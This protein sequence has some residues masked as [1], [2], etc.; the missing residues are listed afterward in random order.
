MMRVKRE[1]VGRKLSLLRSSLHFKF[2]LWHDQSTVY[3][4]YIGIG[5]IGFDDGP[6][7]NYILLYITFRTFW[8]FLADISVISSKFEAGGQ[9]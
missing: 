9:I 2:F 6:E 8:Q 5:Y 1:K 4:G 7:R 3:F